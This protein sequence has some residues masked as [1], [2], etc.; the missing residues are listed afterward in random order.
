[1][2]KQP[3]QPTGCKSSHL[4]TCPPAGRGSLEDRIAKLEV[5]LAPG[6]YSRA[7]KTAAEKLLEARASTTEERL[8]SVALRVT[9]IEERLKEIGKDLN[10][11]FRVSGGGEV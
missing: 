6:A 8:L 2:T 7:G 5:R 11:L 10:T 3:V 4:P 9:A 1:M